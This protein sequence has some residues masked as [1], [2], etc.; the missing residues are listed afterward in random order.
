MLLGLTMKKRTDMGELLTY[1]LTPLSL[2]LCHA[3]GSLLHSLKAAL[4]HRLESKI[5]SSPSSSVDMAIV[6][7]VFFINLQVN[8]PPNFDEVA[9]YIP[10]QLTKVESR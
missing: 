4:W 5:V 2:S 10:A 6:N 9:R 7:A 3:H 1:P 8:L